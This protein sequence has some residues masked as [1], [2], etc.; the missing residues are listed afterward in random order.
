MKQAPYVCL[1]VLWLCLWGWL[2]LENAGSWLLM[3]GL[4]YSLIPYLISPMWKWFL[5]CGNT[6]PVSSLSGVFL[7]ASVLAGMS[8][9]PP[10]LEYLEI[11][12]MLSLLED[13]GVHLSV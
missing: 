7:V 12:Q 5:F 8:V 11:M 1:Q 10:K 6:F 4:A 3:Y 13:L 9:C 2:V